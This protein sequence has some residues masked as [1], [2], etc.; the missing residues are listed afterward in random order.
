MVVCEDCGAV[1]N[2]DSM[3]LHYN[4]HEAMEKQALHIEEMLRKLRHDLLIAY[5]QQHHIR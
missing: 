4:W 3:D 5:Q 2:P 1:V